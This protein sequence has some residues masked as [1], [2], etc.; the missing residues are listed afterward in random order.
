LYVALARLAEQYQRWD[1]AAGYYDQALKIAP[2]DLDAL[3]GYAR[4]KDRMGDAEGA[5][6]LYERAAAANPREGAVFND[7]AIF[8]ARRGDFA[9]AIA[10]MEKAVQL[11]PRRW[12]YRTNLAALLVQIGQY[13]SALAQLQTVQ[14]PATACYN[15]AVMLYRKGDLAQSVRYFQLALVHNPELQP[16]QRWLHQ[17]TSG[18]PSQPNQLGQQH[19]LARQPAGPPPVP[20]PLGP[21]PAPGVSVPATSGYISPAEP[22]P[23][24]QPIRIGQQAFPPFTQSP[25]SAHY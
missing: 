2:K 9:G 6:Q 24:T 18:G 20:P 5:A 15:L 19:E 13:D 8:L 10:R 11:Q 3:L 14:D 4:L 16:A 23:L 7:W 21:V 17:L 25:N 12:L 22:A 1:E